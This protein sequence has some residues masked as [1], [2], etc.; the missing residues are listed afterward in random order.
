MANF[1]KDIDSLGTVALI[2]SD[3]GALRG[4][5]NKERIRA[6]KQ[7]LVQLQQKVNSIVWLNPL[8]LER[9]Q[10]T[11]AGAIARIVP[12]REVSPQGFQQAM[13][14]LRGYTKL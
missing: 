7:F 1:L 6:T 9:W 4:G 8:P 3:G 13:N 2:F 11:T 14:L 5:F 12:M 10:G